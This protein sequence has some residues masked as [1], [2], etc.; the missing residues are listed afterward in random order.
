[1]QLARLNTN[2]RAAMTNHVLVTSKRANSDD[3]VHMYFC[4]LTNEH[5]V[6]VRSACASSPEHCDACVDHE[7]IPGAD[8]WKILYRMEVA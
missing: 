4:Q 7:A 3:H 2:G 8:E 6:N 1:M 5:A